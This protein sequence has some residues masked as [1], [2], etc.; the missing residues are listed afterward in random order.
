MVAIIAEAL[1]V[2]VLPPDHAARQRIVSIV[3]Q[4]QVVVWKTWVCKINSNNSRAMPECLKLVL[5]V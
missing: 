1:A 2:E 3:K 4:V 5:L